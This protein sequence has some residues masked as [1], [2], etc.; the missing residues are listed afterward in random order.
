LVLLLGGQTIAVILLTQ[1]VAVRQI[2]EQ[3]QQLAA[4]AQ[5]KALVAGRDR[6]RDYLQLP[7]LVNTLHSDALQAGQLRP[8]NLPEIEQHL[9]RSVQRFPN[10][11]WVAF[12]NN[13]GELSIVRRVDRAVVRVETTLGNPT[14]LAEDPAG[15]L[16]RLYVYSTSSQ[17]TRLSLV[18]SSTGFQPD[19][20]DWYRAT[21]QAGQAAWGPITTQP[22]AEGDA[23]EQRSLPLGTPVA[24]AQG[25]RMGLVAAAVDLQPLRGILA[26]TVIDPAGIAVI[27]DERGS[28]VAQATPAPQ[29]TLTTLPPELLSALA[30]Q[31]PPAI[32]SGPGSPAPFP[33]T[34]AQRWDADYGGDRYTTLALPLALDLGPNWTIW[35]IQPDSTSLLPQTGGWSLLGIGCASAG[36]AL[37]LGF[38][39]SQRLR[40]PLLQGREETQAIL[41][42]RYEIQI[43]AIGVREIDDLTLA[44]KF[45][46][47]DLNTTL[48][49]AERG[50]AALEERVK[51]RTNALSF[52]ETK[53]SK[54]FYASPSGMCLMRLHDHCILDF[55]D[56][57]LEILGYSFEELMGFSN[58]EFNLWLHP[59]DRT[60][61]MQT[62]QRGENVYNQEVEVRT[63]SREIRTLLMSATTVYILGMECALFVANDITDYKQ[64]DMDLA[65]SHQALSTVAPPARHTIATEVPHDELHSRLHQMETIL[66]SVQEAIVWTDDVGRV[67]WCN[68]AFARL[69]GRDR[70]HLIHSDLIEFLPLV[71]RGQPVPIALHPVTRGMQSLEGTA[72]YEFHA[73][74]DRLSVEISWTGVII[75]AD[76]LGDRPRTSAVLVIRDIS[77]RKRL[78]GEILRA[79]RFID[80]IV[81]NLPLAVYVKDIN[82]DFR[83]VLWNRTAESLFGFP[84]EQ[85]IGR[86]A[87]DLYSRDRAAILHGRDLEAVDDAK[88]LEIPEE[89]LTLKDNRKV[90]VRTLQVPLYDPQ[91]RLSYLLCIADDITQRKRAELALRESQAQFR[92]LA[93]QAGGDLIFI[94]DVQGKILDVNQLAC[95]TLGYSRDELLTMQI[96]DIDTQASLD[97]HDRIW[98]MM[99]PGEPVTL[100]GLYRSK[101]GQNI[102]VEI[103]VGMRK[104]Q[105]Q[106]IFLDMVRDVTDRKQIEEALQ[107]AEEKYR[108]IV[109]NAVEGI[110]QCAPHGQFL[111][112]NLA[113]VR[114]FG[115]DAVEDML[116]PRGLNR[117][118]RFYLDP[119]RWNSFTTLIEQTGAVYNFESQVYAQDG[120]TFWIS[121]NARAVRDVDGK[122][123]Y[124]EGTMQNITERKLA[125]E[126]LFAEQ[127][128]SDRLL[129]NILPQAIANQ[130]KQGDGSLAELFDEATILFA[131][132]VGFTH[133]SAQMRP[134]ELVDMLNRIF[135]TFDQLAERHRLEKIKTVGDEYM[136]VGGLPVPMPDH[137][138]AIA[139]MALD[140]QQAIQYFETPDGKP[141]AIRIG[142]NTGSVV[143][144]VIGIKKFAYDLW[145]DTVN[146]ASRMESQGEPGR[147]QVTTTVYEM[148][149]D[150]FKFEYRGGIEVKGRGTMETYWLMGR[151]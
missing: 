100:E 106:R 66:S 29:G 53:F 7:D 38:W 113:L 49:S 143:A 36:L 44:L 117:T 68:P 109:E 97:Q 90:V 24:D 149:K 88:V 83:Y 48:T 95:R 28:L 119:D 125:E 86:T 75:D 129:L 70:P 45:L 55:N 144:G 74:S 57:F 102:P 33:P 135:S 19:D 62:L 148:L 87:K 43:P 137:V 120:S 58:V 11:R 14:D 4:A 140:M 32:A 121:E 42:G 63:K 12:V 145:G 17:G 76:P 64:L 41:Q 2:H 147:I 72:A 116:G 115:Y 54:V 22:A 78:V 122:L 37:A 10:L 101:R 99:A 126:A 35:V 91:G 39:A 31:R 141:F 92:L 151:L 150:Q 65:R 73:D 6:V 56:R 112:G 103:R 52:S 51:E 18:G 133:M 84:R 110:Y 61:V 118:R 114:M 3:G 142:I 60:T 50:R 81:E 130:L 127:E 139:Q 13:S 104:S 93:D 107:E 128:K 105:G 1:W 20:L 40:V 25:R 138:A 96:Q 30:D 131:D 136:V 8:D 27:V 146:V 108:S 79:K 80:G 34:A 94:H 132:I 23:G 15:D 77:E 124:Y 21:I 98:E 69:V 46:A 67:Q 9:W 71:H 82:Q 134:I 123:L 89:T 47:R 111:S 26:S 59:E 5:A 85:V 16:D